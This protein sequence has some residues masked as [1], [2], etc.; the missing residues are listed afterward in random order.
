MIN[1]SQVRF[2]L[3]VRYY[4]FMYHRNVIAKKLR[5]DGKIINF[6]EILNDVNLITRHFY[7]TKYYTTI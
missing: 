3:F 7:K 1:L 4:H 6:H 2:F 5:Y